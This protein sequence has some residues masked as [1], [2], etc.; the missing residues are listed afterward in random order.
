VIV[1]GGREVPLLVLA[2]TPD[3]IRVL[4]KREASEAGFA[5]DVV[6]V[7]RGRRSNPRRL[8]AWNGSL[9]YTF[10]PAGDIVVRIE[11]GLVVR[12]DPDRVRTAPGM[13]PVAGPEQPTRSQFHFAEAH[14]TASG[15]APA[16]DS[17]GNPCTLTA[18]GSGTVRSDQSVPAAHCSHRGD[19]DPLARTLSISHL[20]VV[21]PGATLSG[22]GDGS[23][24]AVDFG[25]GYISGPGNPLVM[26]MDGAWRLTADSRTGATHHFALEWPSIAP[27][28]AYDPDQPK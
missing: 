7:S 20:M 28:P 13:T 18:S 3:S 4:P 8:M 10:R 11:L 19:F 2:W 25:T 9:L 24:L 6:V 14:W 16:T 27:F 21:R 15:S 17:N 1:D 22:C 23:Y 5:G 12:F 26:V